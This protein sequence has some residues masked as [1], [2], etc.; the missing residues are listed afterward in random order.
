MRL[1]LRWLVS[2]GALMLIAYYLP[3]VKVDGFYTALIAALVLG[4][5]NAIIRPIIHVFALPI[6]ILTLGLF[7][8]V[9]NALII[10][11]TSTM[12]KGFFIDGFWT[13]LL[14]ALIMWVV[15]WLAN[16]LL[17]KE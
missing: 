2:A 5:L 1:L 8:F 15:G 16:I 7:S 17:K 4:L 6:T 10:W 9:I 11:L 13:A 3:G 12:V 14:A